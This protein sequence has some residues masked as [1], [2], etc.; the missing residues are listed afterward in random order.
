MPGLLERFRTK[1]PPLQHSE[2]TLRKKNKNRIKNKIAKQS[3]KKNR[4]PK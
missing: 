1:N 4:R 3:R 2:E